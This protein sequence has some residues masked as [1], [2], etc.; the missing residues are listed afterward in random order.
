MK[1]LIENLRDNRVE[2]SREECAAALERL[3]A[4]RDALA[5]EL[6]DTTIVLKYVREQRELLYSQTFGNRVPMTN[7]PQLPDGVPCSHP[8]CLRHVTHPCEGWATSNEIAA[9][10]EIERLNSRSREMTTN[11]RFTN[12]CLSQEL[13]L[14]DASKEIWKFNLWIQQQ[15]CSWRKQRGVTMRYYAATDSEHKDFDEW[16][17]KRV[18]TGA[19]K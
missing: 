14:A 4:E 10:N 8:G 3:T 13:T 11:P 6:A 16:L 12:Y 18:S 15:W 9:A 17:T 7:P 5:A 19:G 1:Q 2:V